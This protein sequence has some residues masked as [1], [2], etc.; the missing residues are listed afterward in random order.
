MLGFSRKRTRGASSMPR[1]FYHLPTS[2]PPARVGGRAGLMLCAL[3]AVLEPGCWVVPAY[4]TAMFTV[5][6]LPLE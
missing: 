5:Y 6:A 1:D 4:F 2:P 3:D